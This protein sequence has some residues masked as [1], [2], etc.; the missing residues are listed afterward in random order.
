M[1]NMQKTKL[2]DEYKKSPHIK[3]YDALRLATELSL[4]KEQ[5]TINQ[6]TTNQLRMCES[7]Y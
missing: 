5:V 4:T 3:K 2:E 7:L 6:Q 1:N